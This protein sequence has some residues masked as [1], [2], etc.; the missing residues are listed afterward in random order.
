MNEMREMKKILAIMLVSI[1]VCASV[2]IISPNNTVVAEDS[3]KPFADLSTGYPSPADVLDQEQ[4]WNDELHGITLNDWY[5]QTFIP[6]MN[7]PLSKVSVYIWNFFGSG[8][9]NCEI[10]TTD[11]SHHPLAYLTGEIIADGTIPGSYDDWYDIEF[12]SPATLSSGVEY[13]IVMW[14][15]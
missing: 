4:T 1:M 13:T 11:A 3:A 9:L 10:W 14:C 5:S 12:S 15:T 2:V 8:D 6:N 7:G